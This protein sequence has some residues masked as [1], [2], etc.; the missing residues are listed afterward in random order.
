M[1]K[2]I[3]IFPIRLYQRILS[4]MLGAHCRYTPSC[5]QYAVES[6]QEWGVIKGMALGGKRIM[7]CHPWGASGYDPV[8]K[9]NP[10]KN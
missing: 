4:P 1:L 3:F 9:K 7:R 10:K 5:S 8:P 6:I 2:Q